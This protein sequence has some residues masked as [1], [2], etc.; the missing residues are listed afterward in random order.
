MKPNKLIKILTLTFLIPAF[1]L[2][3]LSGCEKD[4]NN[5]PNKPWIDRQNPHSRQWKLPAAWD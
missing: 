3:Y 5:D 4:K 2:L 1:V